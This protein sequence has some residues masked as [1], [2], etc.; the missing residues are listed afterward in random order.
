MEL[1]RSP[2][3]EERKTR[4]IS[5]PE[6]PA[7]APSVERHQHRSRRQEGGW[8]GSE[9]RRYVVDRSQSGSPASPAGR[10]PQKGNTHQ[11]YSDAVVER[12][13]SSPHVHPRSPPRHS[14]KGRRNSPCHSEGS[15]PERCVIHVYIV[16]FFPMDL[17]KLMD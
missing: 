11:S 3:Y 1:Y 5:P 7:R 16:I 9:S 15:S 6:S 2:S 4:D 13:H 10:P 8:S 17:F 12:S 14:G